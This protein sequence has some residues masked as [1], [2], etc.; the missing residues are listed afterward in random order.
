MPTTPQQLINLGE[1]PNDG[2]GEPL[3]LAFAE[4]NNNFA[5]V[6]TAGPVNTNVVISNNR[7]STAIQDRDLELAAAGQG[8]VVAYSDLHTQNILP[9]AES[10]YDLGT[11]AAY[12]DSSYVRYHSGSTVS[13]TGTVTANCVVGLSAFQL[14]VYANTTVRDSTVSAPVP[15]Q[16]VFVTG[17][18]LQ[19][20]GA[21]Q[22]NTVTSTGT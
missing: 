22:W 15:G 12:W 16:M 19:I 6:W 3:R 18:G 2:T 5:N 17:L 14:P 10:A 4:V 1:A 21:T 8:N 11:P 7:I 20:R 9:Q 13:V